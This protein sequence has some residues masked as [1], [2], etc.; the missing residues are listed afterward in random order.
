[1]ICCRFFHPNLD[2]GRYIILSFLSRQINIT[3]PPGYETCIKPAALIKV[4][5]FTQS[6]LIPGKTGF[7]RLLF[8]T[9]V[10]D[11]NEEPGIMI[12]SRILLLS[13]AGS[14]LLHG[15]ALYLTGMV[16]MKQSLLEEKTLTVHLKEEIP[17]EAPNPS[18]EKMGPA[19]EKAAPAPKP[20]PPT[21]GK[22][23]DTVDLGNLSN[24][25]Y[26]PYLVRIKKKI[27][28]TWT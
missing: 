20:E 11:R 16:Q 3:R 24:S 18:P 15:I 26:K 6:A 5:S 13:I 27:E 28:Q 8:Y 23:E 12:T 10:S 1:M 21:A 7:S 14:L 4:K 9:A 22:R 2:E 19:Q 17:Q 25:R